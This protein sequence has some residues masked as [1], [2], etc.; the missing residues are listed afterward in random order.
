MSSEVA[1]NASVAIPQPAQQRADLLP[2]AGLGLLGQVAA[3]LVED[4][5]DLARTTVAGP[6]ARRGRGGHAAWAGAFWWTAGPR[7]SPAV[8][9]V[10]AT[11]TAGGVRRMSPP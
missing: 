1:R 5:V 4:P 8:E 9:A 11:R 3:Q 7:L 6:G 10:T 2:D